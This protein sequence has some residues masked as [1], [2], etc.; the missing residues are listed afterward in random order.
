MTNPQFCRL[1]GHQDTPDFCSRCGLP[2]DP[3]EPFGIVRYVLNRVRVLATPIPRFL[4][5]TALLLLRPVTFFERL[6]QRHCGLHQIRLLRGFQASASFAHWRRPTTPQ[7]YFLF[8]LLLPMVT[9]ARV[10]SGSPPCDAGADPT[11]TLLG[12]LQPTAVL[13]ILEGL[14]V[15]LLYCQYHAYRWVLGLG[16]SRGLMEYVLYTFSLVYMPIIPIVALSPELLFPEELPALVPF[17]FLLV[18]CTYYFVLVPL[19]LR[20]GFFPVSTARV[21]FSFVVMLFLP[22]TVGLFV[23]CAATFGI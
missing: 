21:L 6:N 5:T 15:V 20:G 23:G 22:L 12:V 7:N 16:N 11:G 1:C 8:A 14:L 4:W 10:E 9:L 18:G 2:L 13:L 17:Y 3:G 19:L